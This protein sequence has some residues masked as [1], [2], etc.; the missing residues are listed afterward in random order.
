MSDLARQA[1]VSEVTEVYTQPDAPELADADALMSRRQERA[2]ADG[3]SLAYN[4]F[5]KRSSAVD[6]PVGACP[7]TSCP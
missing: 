1:C 7:P 6:S 5:Q 2:G 3:A 4:R